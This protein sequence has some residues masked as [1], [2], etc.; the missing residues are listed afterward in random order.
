MTAHRV[1]LD[2]VTF[3]ASIRVT[4]VARDYDYR[5]EI[6]CRSR[7]L[8]EIRGAD[9]VRRIGSQGIFV[10]WPYE[11]LGSQVKDHTGFGGL[12]GICKPVEIS[13]VPDDAVHLVIEAQKLARPVSPVMSLM[14]L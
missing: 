11:R 4:L 5:V 1:L 7:N 10:R 2:V 9:H 13:D 3:V 14:T 6:A 8:E 12:Y